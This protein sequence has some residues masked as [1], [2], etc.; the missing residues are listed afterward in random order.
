VFL[1]QTEED[2]IPEW[3][4]PCMTV[5]RSAL[6]DEHVTVDRLVELEG[7]EEEEEEESWWRVV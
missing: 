3:V 1:H 2:E 6:V 7:E 5:S 4:V